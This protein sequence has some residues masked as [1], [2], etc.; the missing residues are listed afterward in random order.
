LV[1]PAATFGRPPLRPRARAAAKPALEGVQSTVLQYERVFGDDDEWPQILEA[2]AS[3]HSGDYRR[4]QQIL[5]PI[6][7]REPPLIPA[8]AVLSTAYGQMG[9]WETSMKLKNRLRNAEPRDNFYDLDQ[10]FTGYGLIWIDT[11]GAAKKLKEVLDRRPT[12]L[13]CH[14]M[15]ANSWTVLAVDTDDEDLIEAAVRKSSATV[16]LAQNSRFALNSNLFALRTAIEFRQS[17]QKEYD[18]LLLTS[19]RVVD[20]LRQYP[21]FVLGYTTRSQY[22]DAIDDPL[23]EEAWVHVLEESSGFWRWAAVG[24]LYCDRPED[25]V[26]TAL[27]DIENV[28][29]DKFAMAAKAYLLTNLP[30]GRRE[31]LRI[32][33]E[34]V[35]NEPTLVQCYNAVHIL[36]LLGERERAR[37]D[38]NGWLNKRKR[39]SVVSE[40]TESEVQET[41]M[42]ELV[43]KEGPPSQDYSGRCEEIFSH[44]FLGLI[45]VADG[46]REAAIQHFT[47]SIEKPHIN[48]DHYWGTAFLRRMLDDRNWPRENPKMVDS[49]AP[50]TQP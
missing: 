32:Y 15:L 3:L 38:A 42:L 21:E 27:E 5:E 47:K 1:S 36:L 9:D 40:S 45:A 4:A 37:Q 33:D 22:Y 29:D 46:D 39:Q 12:W 24:R 8:V 2:T 6:V 43:A 20:R 41:K 16:E 19:E 50:S 48:I 10:L 34:L 11:K 31:A 23:A 18:D 26:L 35:T 17:R 49:Y 25:E 13:T 44:H 14:A 30:D 7:D 28:S